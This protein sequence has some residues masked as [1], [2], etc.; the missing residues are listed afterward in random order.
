MSVVEKDTIAP[1][2]P[3]EKVAFAS[4]V[5][6]CVLYTN[7]HQNTDNECW[8]IPVYGDIHAVEEAQSWK[9]SDAQD[10]DHVFFVLWILQQAT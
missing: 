5:L 3:I 9:G 10:G 7:P 4:I 6:V 2:A 1:A 8:K